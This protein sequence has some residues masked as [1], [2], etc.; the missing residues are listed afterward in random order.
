MH[1]DSL[2]PIHSPFNGQKCGLTHAHILIIMD[3][4][5]KPAVPE[6]IN[7]VDSAEFPD[8]NKK[9]SCIQVWNG[10]QHI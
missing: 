8:D 1:R 6:F 7:N 9:D 5:Y 4:Q 10:A 3:T 2:S